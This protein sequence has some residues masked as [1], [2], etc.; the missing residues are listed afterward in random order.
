MCDEVVCER[1][2][3]KKGGGGGGGRGAGGGMQKQ[4][5]EPHTMM[6]GKSKTRYPPFI[7]KHM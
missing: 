1:L 3:V 2:C 4:K 7:A 6:W 5:L